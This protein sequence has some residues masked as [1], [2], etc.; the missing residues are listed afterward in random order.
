MDFEKLRRF[1]VLGLSTA[2]EMKSA[3]HVL[4]HVGHPALSHLIQTDKLDAGLIARFRRANVP[5]AWVPAAAHPR[6]LHELVR[7]C[8]ALKAARV[9]EL[10]CQKSGFAS[11]VVARFIA[12]HID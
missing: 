5:P 1:D 9:Q 6:E 11:P 10:S 2:A 12:T 4:K 7:R 8:D 3:K